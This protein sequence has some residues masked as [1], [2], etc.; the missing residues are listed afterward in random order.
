MTPDFMEELDDEKGVREEEYEEM[1]EI[2][3]PHGVL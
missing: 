1:G 3:K 2:C